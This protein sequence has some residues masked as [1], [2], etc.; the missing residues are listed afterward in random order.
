MSTSSAEHPAFP[1]SRLDSRYP[2]K[3]EQRSD[4]IKLIIINASMKI[5]R[6]P[7]H[8][9]LQDLH[10]IVQRNRP[11]HRIIESFVILDPHL[12]FALATA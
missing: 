2:M 9:Y 12:H 4:E 7:M 6:W 3:G 11:S 10:E 1:L 5:T 8:S